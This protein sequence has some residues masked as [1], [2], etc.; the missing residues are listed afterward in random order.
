MAGM[1][2]QMRWSAA[3]GSQ[4]MKP[5]EAVAGALGAIRKGETWSKMEAGHRNG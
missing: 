5:H 3:V 4:L 1:L 2:R